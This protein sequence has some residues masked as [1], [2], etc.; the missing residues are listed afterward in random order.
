[1]QNA[2]DA[3]SLKYTY[4]ISGSRIVIL[5]MIREMLILIPVNREYLFL[6]LVN[7]AQAPPF[8]PS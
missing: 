8:R 2:P 1:M 5:V 4:T 6:F 3:D 7:C